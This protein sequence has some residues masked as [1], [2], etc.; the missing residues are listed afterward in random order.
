MKF[1]L[2]HTDSGSK[3]RAGVLTTDHGE[4]KTPIFM[5]VGTVG[6]VK[7]VQIP[8]LKEDIKAQIILSKRPADSTSSILGTVLS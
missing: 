6:S 1:N 4:I 8:H 2:L 5:P 3:A 7:G